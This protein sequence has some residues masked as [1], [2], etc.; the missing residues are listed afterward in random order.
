MISFYIY[1]QIYSH[2]FRLSLTVKLNKPLDLKAVRLVE[3]NC[4]DIKWNKVESGACTVKYDVKLKDASG[5]YC[6]NKTGYNIRE[7]KICN[8]KDFA[9]ITHV[10]MMAS[11]KNVTSKASNANI[12]TQAQFSPGIII[13]LCLFSYRMTIFKFILFTSVC[14]TINIYG[15]SID[16]L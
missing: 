16:C 9:N 5:K 1:S 2:L 7:M 8:V 6:H 13:Y 15:I 10:E 12:T 4:I 14:F 3:S 11:F